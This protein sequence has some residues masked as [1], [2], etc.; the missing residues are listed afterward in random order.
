MAVA[1]MYYRTMMTEAAAY[2]PD[3]MYSHP[4]RGE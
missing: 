3:F 4:G 1:R 2:G